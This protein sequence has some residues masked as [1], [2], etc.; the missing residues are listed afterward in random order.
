MTTEIDMPSA[1]LHEFSAL[2]DLVYQ[3]ATDASKW[4]V[5]LGVLSD[6]LG[7]AKCLL[8]TQIGRAH[9]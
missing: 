9:V 5:I 3:G 6:W 2:L 1:D 7:S 4:P 8:F